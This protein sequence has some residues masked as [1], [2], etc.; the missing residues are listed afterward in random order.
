MKNNINKKLSIVENLFKA[1]ILFGLLGFTACTS[2]QTVSLTSIPAK[3][4]RK[5]SAVADKIIF[6]GLNFDNDYVDQLVEDLKRQCPNGLVSGVLTKDEF[7]NYFIGL[8][9]K[10]R[11]S[12]AGYCNSGDHVVLNSNGNGL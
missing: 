1:F 8:V 12:A 7:V 3:R 2:L 4:A 5:V 11:I 6:L 9:Y 10:H